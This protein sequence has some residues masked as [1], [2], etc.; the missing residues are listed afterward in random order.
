M[1][2]GNG[3]LSLW[4]SLRSSGIGPPETPPGNP[5][6]ATIPGIA[7]WWDASRLDS[8]RDGTGQLLSDWSQNVS[9]VSNKSGVQPDLLSYSSSSAM[10]A[11]SAAP[12]VAGM[13]GGIGALNTGSGLSQPI[14]S[15]YHGLRY[16]GF[17][18]SAAADWTWWMVWSR[19][20]W[21]QG[22]N[23]DGS[24]STILSVAS[25]TVIQADNLGGSGRLV[26]FPGASAIT[27]STA[28]SRRHTH[29]IILRHTASS[30][31]DV[32]LDGNRV[33]SNVTNQIPATVGGPTWLLHDG[34]PIGGAQCWFHE[35][36]NWPRSLQD[37][38]IATLTTYAARW[39][40]GAR[41]GISLLVNGQSNAINYALN[42][43]AALLLA[44][45][46][47]WHLGAIAYG[48]VGSTGGA[49]NYTMASGHGLYPV[50]NGAYPGSFVDPV[51]GG[52]PA[53]W[54]LG[55][56]GIALQNAVT[57][58]S[59]EDRSDIRALLWPWN[60]TDSLRSYSEKSTFAAAVTRFLD[61]ERTMVGRTANDLPLIWW[62]AIPYGTAG[63]MQM[64]RELTAAFATDPLMNV[65]I[66]NPQ[67]S[68]SNPRGSSWDPAT[69]QWA[70]GDSAH[71]DGVDNRR[72]AML[73][74]PVVARALT[75]SGFADTLTAIPAGIPSH[76]G[77]RIIHVSQRDATSLVLTVQ[78]D[79]GNDLVVP[80]QAAAGAGFTVMDGG[81]AA[82]PG[83]LVNAVSCVRTDATHLLLTLSQPL[84]SAASSST[85]YYPYGSNMIGRGNAV[86]DNFA[87]IA[88]P[89]GWDIGGDL[90]S[91]WTLNYPLAASEI[92]ISAT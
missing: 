47:A 75:N 26:L 29:S 8:L 72:F 66:G 71:R 11:L 46:I 67:T 25:R 24:P 78:H 39:P 88:R 56:D 33:A 84:A 82:S 3:K 20:N 90:G 21:R 31:I 86:T 9:T 70:G 44:R 40:T 41:R 57:S 92:P 23:Q 16:L 54:P 80:L 63:G 30:G 27:L 22:T 19:P 77:P 4:R 55:L 1:A 48:V 76:G 15:P 51:N 50:A 73:A 18:P 2:I 64:H 28:L 32:W 35:A 89:V 12:R 81:S 7:G 6:P 62:N 83:P 74:A 59:P 68:D 49:T 37:T 69:G 10:A 58:L 34:T 85:L 17:P 87:S 14:L 79:S 42:D 52:D 5:S 38:E 53:S 45:G 43:G 13:L 61:L 65:V 60:E 36:A 91:A